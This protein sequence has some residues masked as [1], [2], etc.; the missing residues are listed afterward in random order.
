MDWQLDAAELR[1]LG[2]LMEKE[3]TTP[4][5]YPM[6]LNALV[7]ACNQKSNREPVVNFD[8]ET[9]ET[10]LHELRAKGLSSRISGESRVPKHEQRFV[11]KFNLGRREAAVMCVLMLRGPQTVGEL[12]GRTERIFTFDDL[13]GVESTLQR[14][15]EI[16]F[17]KKLPRQTGYK[18]QRWAQLLAGDI[19]VAEEAAPAMMERGASDRDRIAALEEE[20]AELKRAFEQFRRNFE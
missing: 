15:A 7:N 14:L 4:D 17:V 16:G 11:E 9:V 8:E 6:S 20:V 18:E 1:V 13:E 5:Y 19:E 2:A 3:A 10:A 12:R